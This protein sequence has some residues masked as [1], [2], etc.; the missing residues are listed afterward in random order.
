MPGIADPGAVIVKR[1]IN[2]HQVKPLVGP[3]SI[4]LAMMSS[5]LNGQTLPL[6]DI[7]PSIK[8]NEKSHKN[9]RKQI[10]KL[11]QS[12]IFMETPYRNEK[13]LENL[14]RVLDSETNLCIAYDLT[15][16]GEFIKT[17]DMGLWKKTN[18]SFHK[19]PAIFIIHKQG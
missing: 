3:S 4:L 19:R 1:P 16:P 14:K 12:Q 6:T 18:M 10:T 8:K 11:D 7:F 15:Q 5:G 17:M 2:E 9:F 13:L